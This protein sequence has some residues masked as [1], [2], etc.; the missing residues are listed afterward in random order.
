MGQTPILT[1]QKRKKIL[2]WKIHV[3]GTISDKIR[4]KTTVFL[5]SNQ[6]QNYYYII[7]VKLFKNFKVVAMLYCMLW[8]KH[9]HT[10][11]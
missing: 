1:N 4:L 8:L 3:I 10:Q 11:Y 6:A 5:I 2:E 7:Q 9:K